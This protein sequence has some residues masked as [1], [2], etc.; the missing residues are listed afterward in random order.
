MFVSCHRSRLR[1]FLPATLTILI[2][3]CG[4]DDAHGLSPKSPE[5][6]AMISKGAEYLKGA[7]GGRIGAEALIGL[8]LL[9]CDVAADDPRITSILASV[10]SEVNKSTYNFGELYTPAALAVFL[11][12]LDAQQFAPEIR[13]MIRYLESETRPYGAWGYP[14]GHGHDGTADTSMT[15]YVMLALWEADQAGFEIST[16]AVESTVLWL[17]KTQDPSGAFGYQGKISTG[18]GLVAQSGVSVSLTAAGLGAVYLSEDA[19]GLLREAR[20][21]DDGLPAALTKVSTKEKKKKTSLSRQVFLGIQGRGNAWLAKNRTLQAGQ[22]KYYFFYSY[23]RYWAL[24][25]LAGDKPSDDW[26]TWIANHL[27]ETQADDGSWTGHLG[28]PIETCFS[29]LCLV[30]SMKKSIQKDRTYGTGRLVGGRG[31]PKDSEMVQIRDGKVVSQ[32][33]VSVIENLLEDLGKAKEEDYAKAIGAIDNLPPDE[34]TALVSQQAARLRQLA[35]GTSADQ[36]LAAVKALARAG[37][38]DD[39]PTL[40]YVLT[41]PENEI[42]LAARDG[43]RRISRKIH[44]FQMPDDFDEGERESAIRNWKNWYL[45]IRPDAEFEN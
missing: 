12:E 18:P 20:K 10:R 38:L 30:R 14:K 21:E 27:R 5:V 7:Q 31:L 37:T 15:L 42:V 45:A 22:F 17:S 39:V 35:G 1:W 23:E 32:A 40:I 26:Y 11:L 3:A 13:K 25:E 43:L 6:K 29:L 4:F 28:A 2:V 34:V 41:D 44:G 9:K 24:R 8:T 16:R 19:L 33:E 36:R